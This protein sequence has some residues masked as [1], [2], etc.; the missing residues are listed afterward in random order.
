MCRAQPTFINEVLQPKPKVHFGHKRDPILASVLL[1]ALIRF[2]NRYLLCTKSVPPDVTKQFR[3]PNYI[4][5]EEWIVFTFPKLPNPQDYLV[6]PFLFLELASI[7]LHL[8]IFSFM[9]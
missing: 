6:I 3:V 7:V 4:I 9:N 2:T 5:R 1:S 8:F